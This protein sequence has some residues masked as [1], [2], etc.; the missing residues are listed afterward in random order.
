MIQE[1]VFEKVLKALETAE[2]PYMITGSI[3]SIHYG[4][5]RV[6]YDMDIVSQMNLTKVQRFIELLGSEFYADPIDIQESIQY[7][8]EFNIIHPSSGLKVDF[9]PVKDKYDELRFQRRKQGPFGTISAYFAS[10][11]DIILK[12]LDWVKQGASA[13]HIED[14]KGI[15]AVQGDKI[16]RNYITTWAKALGLNEYLATIGVGN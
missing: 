7:Q 5:P 16:D 1:E 3:A 15:L 4:K 6:T 11:E 10:A 8:R 9:W 13:R 12:K 14:I 2:I